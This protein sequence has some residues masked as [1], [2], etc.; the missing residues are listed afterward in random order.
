[1]SSTPDTISNLTRDMP[2]SSPPSIPSPLL[3]ANPVP[4]VSAALNA[5]WFWNPSPRDLLLVIPRILSQAGAFAP[6]NMPEWIDNLLRARN[7]GSV[8]AEAT[9]S[10][11]DSMAAA[12]L[13]GMS[14]AQETAAAMPVI[15]AEGGQLG[16]GLFSQSFSFQQLR[17]LGGIFTYMTSKWALTCFALVSREP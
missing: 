13:S 7:G 5:T 2:A 11:I 16:Q 14:S 1:M 8:I 12:A 17:N 4:L 6:N 10:R 3:T 9:G 15:S